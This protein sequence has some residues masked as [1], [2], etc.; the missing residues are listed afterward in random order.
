MRQTLKLA[1]IGLLLTAIAPTAWAQDDDP[2][3]FYEDMIWFRFD[4]AVGDFVEFD[5]ANDIAD[6]GDFMLV[7]LIGVYDESATPEE[8]ED[9]NAEPTIEE[10]PGWI[11]ITARPARIPPYDPPQQVAPPSATAQVQYAYLLLTGDEPLDLNIAIPLPYLLGRWQSRLPSDGSDIVTAVTIYVLDVST[12]DPLRAFTLGPT[13]IA[14]RKRLDRG[15]ANP[16]PQADA[17]ADQIA[18]KGTTVTLDGSR[19]FD[20]F[21][22][23]FDPNLDGVYER[24][25]LSYSW[26]AF[27]VP[28]GAEG[29]YT[30]THTDESSP[31][32]T[33]ELA[34][35]V[36]GTYLFRLT[37]VDNVNP[38]PSYDIVAISAVDEMPPNAA[39][40]AA[41][42]GPDEPVEVGERVTLMSDSIDPEG[43]PL[44]YRWEQTD[45]LGNALTPEDATRL[46]QPISGVTERSISWIATKAGT[47]YFRLVVS[48]GELLD[49][50]TFALVVVEGDGSTEAGARDGLANEAA[51]NDAQ[52]A[53]PASSAPACGGG[54]MFPLLAI[55]VGLLAIRRRR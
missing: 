42:V 44:T 29:A 39:P 41:I 4:S 10:V 14:I 15:Y 51:D 26:E 12:W 23:G 3:A 32:A 33:V 48:D 6:E 47:Y 13:P 54:M 19:T 20:G 24:D 2:P 52:D 1:V 8:T 45:E 36:V 38:E 21:N 50:A 17:G 30:L 16:G 18:V 34:P 46:F 11:V 5:P 7:Q 37:V 25:F 22:E 27:S 53:P 31:T 9:P 28:A 43:Q 55:P 40:L 35:D 49:V